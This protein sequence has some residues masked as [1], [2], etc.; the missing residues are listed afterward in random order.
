[1][2]KIDEAAREKVMQYLKRLDMLDQSRNFILRRFPAASA[3]A[4]QLLC[5]E[6]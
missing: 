2:E 6:H 4:Q 3:S 1:M 5:S